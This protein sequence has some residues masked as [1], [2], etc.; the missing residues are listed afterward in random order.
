MS[1]AERHVS[2]HSPKSNTVYYAAPSTPSPVRTPQRHNDLAR[3][4]IVV[5][6]PSVISSSR[7][8]DG[9]KH[10]SP[11][12][13]P[14]RSSTRSTSARTKEL[15]SPIKSSSI[16][17]PFD[18]K[19][20]LQVKA[21][22]NPAIARANLDRKVRETEILAT[23]SRSSLG[24]PERLFASESRPQSNRSAV[25][26]SPNIS[27][28]ELQANFM[29]SDGRR[30]RSSE[31]PLDIRSPAKRRVTVSKRSNAAPATLSRLPVKLSA[32]SF[33]APKIGHLISP[34]KASR[35]EIKFLPRTATPFRE[36]RDPN[37]ITPTRDSHSKLRSSLKKTGS[38]YALQMLD[39]DPA[40]AALGE[41]QDNV[42]S[43]NFDRD[44]NCRIPTHVAASAQR[45][46]YTRAPK[47][48][49]PLAKGSWHASDSSDNNEETSA[50][51]V[52]TTD[53]L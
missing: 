16:P 15:K 52:L 45:Q 33:P 4:K 22:R 17:Q 44:G 38:R 8:T 28:S 31:G 49:S 14:T 13:S 26:R 2:I 1:K 25:D 39:R 11:L 10:A 19:K 53:I 35:A 36:H 41:T 40:L 29:T 42:P 51:M 48:S 24:K 9:L 32:Y 20:S 7:R 23:P 18:P 12:V 6:T 3:K 47:I 43:L 27:R 21:A 37:V 50:D 30:S 5:F 46:A 34:S